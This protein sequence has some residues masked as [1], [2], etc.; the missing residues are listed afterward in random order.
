MTHLKGDHLSDQT[1]PV[2]PMDRIQIRTTTSN[3][4]KRGLQVSSQGKALAPWLLVDLG[5]CAAA[6]DRCD[7]HERVALVHFA[8]LRL[9][10]EGLYLAKAIG[11]RGLSTCAGLEI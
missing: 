2:R 8:G 5:R 11:R 10:E 6:C 1:Q 9:V 4:R 3:C 7:A